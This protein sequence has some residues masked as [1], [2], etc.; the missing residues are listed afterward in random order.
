MSRRMAI[1]LAVAVFVS[2]GCDTTLAFQNV[3]ARVA[4]EGGLAD[5]IDKDYYNE[6]TLLTLRAERVGGQ[7]D[8]NDL[9]F[10]AER[11][12]S[13]AYSTARCLDFAIN[14]SEDGYASANALRLASACS[15]N[16]P[17]IANAYRSSMYNLMDHCGGQSYIIM[18]LTPWLK[19]YPLIWKDMVDIGVVTDRSID[20]TKHLYRGA[21][22]IID[23]ISFASCVLTD[24]TYDAQHP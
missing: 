13:L 18:P 19:N 16:L 14:V 22:Q 4:F 20:P 6:K 5:K 17:V 3:E 15:D 8:R 10:L 1:S 24:P 9:R 7:L 11:Y 23:I 12:I 2:G 21:L